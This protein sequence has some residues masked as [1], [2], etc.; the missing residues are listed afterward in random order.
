MIDVPTLYAD[1]GNG[2]GNYCTLNPLDSVLAPTDGNLRYVTSGGAQP[3][4]ATIKFPTSGK[5][6]CEATMTSLGGAGLTY[7]GLFENRTSSSNQY[8]YQSDGNKYSVAGGTVSYGATYTTGDV[9]GLAV[10]VDNGTITFYKNNTSQGTAFTGVSA[11]ILS[12]VAVGQTTGS[13][14]S[15]TTDFNFGQRPFTYTPPTGFKALNTQNLPAP[16]ILKGNQFFDATT[17][18]GDGAS[19]RTI[20]GLAFQ[21][22]FIW[23][24]RRSSGSVNNKDHWL[25]DSVRGAGSNSLR[26][27]TSNR[28]DAEFDERGSAGNAT[29]I[30][31]SGFTVTSGTTN[32]T[33]LNESGN[34]FV[35][36]QW[37]ANGSAV[38]N[39][40]GSITS[41]VN[42][43]TSQGFSVVTW[44]GT[45]STATVG[46]GLGVAPAMI[47]MKNRTQGAAGYNWAVYHKSISSASA[48]VDLNTTAGAGTN[49]GIWNA[50]APTSTVFSVGTARI[51]NGDL[52]VAYCFSEVAGFS[53]FGSYTGNG[54]AD[55]PFVFCG[56]RPR[57][58]M[59][60]RTDTVGSWYMIDTARGTVNVVNPYLIAN[61]ANAEA[62]DLSWDLLSNGFKLRSTYTEI[63]ASSG[64]FIY[65]AFAEHPFK[66]SLAR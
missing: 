65:A 60:K 39:T 10:D 8:L 2:R 18:T 47:I 59:I 11:S 61:G 5:Y 54:S 57:F 38:T 25:F 4:V 13:A 15:R 66:N 50:T 56:F 31:S 62:T 19:S 44:T 3:C 63:N 33:N 14:T 49:T 7:F 53:K 30:T 34:A 42:A 26:T 22:D 32:N 37:K 21:P 58:V 9:I 17:W 27:L 16:T 45:G 12:M 48:F 51:N 52:N 55:G 6:Y 36:W 40:S 29:A 35:G 28:T 23:T 43:G 20:G 1:G 46:H 24:K 64:T 41:Q